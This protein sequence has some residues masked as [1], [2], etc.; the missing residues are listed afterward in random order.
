MTPLQ[1]LATRSSTPSRLMQAPGPNSA[2]LAQLLTIAMRVPD[3]GKLAPWR[4]LL[5]EGDARQRMSDRLCARKLALEPTIGV[6]A[7]EKER[8]RFLHAPSVVVVIAQLTK[9]HK[10]PE[11]EQLMSAAAV[12]MQLLNAAAAMGFACQWLTGWAAYDSNIAEF[13][14][15]K[16]N[17]SVAGFMHLGS[18]DAAPTERVRPALADKLSAL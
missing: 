2:E 10:I 4:F 17:E 11:I 14:Q 5:I 9:P 12:C 3:H 15:L 16:S 7:L 18:T 6:D 1:Q 13:L 8:L